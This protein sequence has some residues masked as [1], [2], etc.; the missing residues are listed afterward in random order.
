MSDDRPNGKKQPPP[1]WPASEVDKKFDPSP[2]DYALEH[3]LG[4]IHSELRDLRESIDNKFDRI[5]TA[6][7]RQKISADEAHARLDAYLTHGLNVEK[8]VAAL[9][10]VA[11]PIASAP[12]RRVA[13]RKK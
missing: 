1:P 9:E 3:R 10:D 5:L 6:I 13:A 11:T 4:L 8:R 2:P 12:K 7:E